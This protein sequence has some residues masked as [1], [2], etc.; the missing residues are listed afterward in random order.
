M[1]VAGRLAAESR[2]FAVTVSRIVAVPTSPC[3]GKCRRKSRTAVCWGRSETHLRSWV[4]VGE[5]EGHVMHV[6]VSG[7]LF[8]TCCLPDSTSG[9][10]RG[11]G[12]GDPQPCPPGV[13]SPAPSVAWHRRTQGHCLGQTQSQ[14]CWEGGDERKGPEAGLGPCWAG[15]VPRS[16]VWAPLR[17]AFW[18]L[19]HG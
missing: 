11:T 17:C 1:R 19:S 3:A 7:Q 8:C 18:H 13:S 2:L 5:G 6:V 14:G 16:P 4:Q 10:A 15:R 9:R 12:Q